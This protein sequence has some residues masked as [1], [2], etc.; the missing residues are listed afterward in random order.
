MWKLLGLC[1]SVQV[2]INN[3]QAG[4]EKTRKTHMAAILIAQVL[5]TLFHLRAK[6]LQKHGLIFCSLT[7]N[8]IITVMVKI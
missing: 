2:E 7:D 3:I 5:Q 4:G 8:K 6:E 1:I